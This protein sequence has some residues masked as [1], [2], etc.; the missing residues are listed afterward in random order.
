M[1]GSIKVPLAQIVLI[2]K[3]WHRAIFVHD[4]MFVRLAD[5]DQALDIL[6]QGEQTYKEP[7]QETNIK[8]LLYIILTSWK[9]D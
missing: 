3:L 8:C 6:V 9:K 5:E 4:Q 7:S 1:T 2:R